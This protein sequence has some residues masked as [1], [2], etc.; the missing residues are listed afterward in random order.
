MIGAARDSVL[1]RAGEAVHA[2]A[3]SVADLAGKGA[4]TAKG[5][6][7]ETEHSK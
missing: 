3:A 4:E 1:E 7:K 6:A 2:A 5:Q